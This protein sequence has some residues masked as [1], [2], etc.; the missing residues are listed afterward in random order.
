MED[1]NRDVSQ[2]E[3]SNLITPEQNQKVIDALVEFVVRASKAG[4]DPYEVKVLPEV[5]RV[6]YDYKTLDYIEPPLKRMLGV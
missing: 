5:A 1:Q 2:Q 3:I 6:L 4:V